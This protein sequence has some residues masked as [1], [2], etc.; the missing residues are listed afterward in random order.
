[1]FSYPGLY[2]ADLFANSEFNVNIRT[3]VSI[4]GI[5]QKNSW[6]NKR[7]SCRPTSD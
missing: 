1:M 6:G 2:K 3:N 7:L 4:S 5:P